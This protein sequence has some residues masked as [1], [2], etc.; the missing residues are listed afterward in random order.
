MRKPDK[1]RMRVESRDVFI[2]DDDKE[3]ATSDE[4]YD[5]MLRRDIIRHCDDRCSRYDLTTSEVVDVILEKYDIIPHKE[6]T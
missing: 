1:P 5:Y 6:T 3:F 4:C 2:A